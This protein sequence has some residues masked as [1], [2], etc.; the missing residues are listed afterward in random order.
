MFRLPTISLLAAH[1]GGNALPSAVG[2]GLNRANARRQM[3]SRSGL[4][5][6]G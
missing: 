2:E 5:T 3:R 1:L 6:T 4:Q